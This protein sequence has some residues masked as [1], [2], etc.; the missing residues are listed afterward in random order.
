LKYRSSVAFADMEFIAWIRKIKNTLHEC[1]ESIRHAEERKRHQELP[2]NQPVEIRAVVSF[3]DKTAGDAKA[4]N[5]R[6]HA[7]QQSIKKATWGAVVAASVYAFIAGF[8]SCQMVKQNRIATDAL[9]QS[10]QSFRIDE[11]AWIGLDPLK[12]T[13]FAPKTD[14]IGAAF[15]YPIYIRNFGKTVARGIQ[16]RASRNGSQSSIT[17]GDNAEAIKWAQDKLLVGEIPSASD[18]P[19]SNPVPKVLAPNTASSVPITLN[20][21]E[22]QY[23][24]KDVW[25]S[26]LIGRVDYTDAFGVPHWVKFC[27]FVADAQGNLWNCKEGNDEDSNPEDPRNPS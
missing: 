16:L 2:D 17:M 22:P 26:Y 24:T 10:T 6:T 25:V 15:K 27:F 8:Q 20:G 3:S 19:I 4:E 7:I 18:I 9:W 14:K 21:Q 11:R 5:D 1:A 13:M 23:F 12:G